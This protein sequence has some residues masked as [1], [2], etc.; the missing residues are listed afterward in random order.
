MAIRCSGFNSAGRFATQP[1]SECRRLFVSA[2]SRYLL[3]R[4]SRQRATIVHLCV[5]PACR[6]LG[7]ARL[8]VEELKQV[9]KPLTGIGLRCRQDNH[10]KL[11]WPKMGFTAMGRKPGRGKD[12]HELT[13]WWFD[14]GH[15]DLLS[16][17][18]PEDRRSPVVIDANVF[19]DLQG[20]D[21]RNGEDSQV[22]QADW[23]QGTIELYVTKE[24]HNEIDRAPDKKTHADIASWE[25]MNCSL[26][27][28][29]RT[30]DSCSP[31][32]ETGLVPRYKV[33]ALFS[34]GERIKMTSVP[35]A[36]GGF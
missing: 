5:D 14:H 20:C 26:G 2:Q 23:V 25:F 19:F 4:V 22:L 24:I 10:A 30:V 34:A 28:R 16:S 29:E 31:V 18:A 33:A 13:F 15:P 35:S 9:T 32:K 7:V 36:K 8:L 12:R 11:L 17:K 3:Y 6:A 21:S 1:K 27:R